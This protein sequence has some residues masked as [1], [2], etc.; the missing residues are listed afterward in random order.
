M[1]I[2]VK[3]ERTLKVYIYRNYEVINTTTYLANI[4]EALK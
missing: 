2:S 1:I 3:V 4:R